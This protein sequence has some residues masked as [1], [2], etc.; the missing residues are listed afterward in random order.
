MVDVG[1]KSVTRREAIAQGCV[2]LSKEA[3]RIVHEGTARKGDVLG[4]ARIAGIQAAKRTADW[5]PLCH[6]LPIESISID[7]TLCDEEACVEIEACVRVEAKTG[8]EMEAMVAVSAA[9]LTIY[10]MC[11]SV[12]RGMRISGLRLKRKS[13]GKSGLYEASDR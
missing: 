10:D 8:V 1:P 2:H 13:G 7:F 12:D 4:V 9:A 3:L 6:P 11:K 5:I